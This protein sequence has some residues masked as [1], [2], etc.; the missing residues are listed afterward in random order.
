MAILGGRQFK[1]ADWITAPAYS[2]TIATS[3]RGAGS[4]HNVVLDGDLARGLEG[5]CRNHPREG[6]TMAPKP[7]LGVPLSCHFRATNSSHGRCQAVNRE[8][9]R[10]A[11]KPP[12]SCADTPDSASDDR[13]G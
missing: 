6:P 5:R 13:S 11:K 8:Q 1:L 2:S 3:A 10:P 12:L 9:W 7:K 4:R